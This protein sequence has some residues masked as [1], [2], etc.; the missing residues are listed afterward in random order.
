MNQVNK[1]NNHVKSFRMELL[2]AL[3]LLVCAIFWGS[4]KGT[5]I[6]G[7]GKG[8]YAYLPAAFIYNDFEY[9]F[10][11]SYE[12]DYYEPQS[13]FDF[14][15]EADGEIVNIT[16]IGM[17]VLWLPFFLV[18]HLLSQVFGLPADGYS[19][20]YQYSVGFAA[21]I[22]LLAGLWALRKLLL[23]Y[24]VKALYIAIIQSLIV[25]ATPIYYYTTVEASFT[26]VYSFSLIVLFTYTCKLLFNKGKPRFLYF[27]A[28]ILG[29]II[30]IRPSNIIILAAV[31]FIAGSFEKLKVVVLDS[32]RNYQVLVIGFLITAGIVSLQ[33][34]MWYIQTGLLYVYAYTGLGFNFDDPHMLAVLFSYR[35]GLFIYTPLMF[36]SLLGFAYLI[37]KSTYE[38]F[39]LILFL[40]F[41]TY[42]ISSWCNW[43]YGM[44][45]GHRQYI[46]FYVFFALLLGFAFKLNRLPIRIGLIVFSVLFMIINL[47]QTYQYKNFI[48]YWNMNK[49]MYWRVFL[50]TG[51]EYEG[52][53]WREAE[54]ERHSFTR[55]EASLAIKSSDPIYRFSN[56]YDNDG[57]SNESGTQCYKGNGCFTLNTDQPYSQGFKS[58]ISDL[59]FSNHDAYFESSFYVFIPK[60]EE[61]SFS[62]VFSVEQDSKTY[63]YEKLDGE[64][65]NLP[66][67]QWTKVDLITRLTEYRSE[68]DIIKIYVWYRGTGSIYLDEFEMQVYD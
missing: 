11:D 67:D 44:S 2:I 20:L 7:D 48:L 53:L 50:K 37:R 17:A 32:I 21:I 24:K 8:Y 4:Y 9:N 64:A 26:H 19:I 47:I 23:L 34:L 5:Y 14:R 58:R 25:F 27:T 39:T 66:E 36:L 38:T 54:K 46:D 35:K 28:L 60:G 51:I 63:I 42:I 68:N 40:I 29:L 22:Y 65:L 49:E 62:L 18:A 55:Y 3:L 6:N 43:W 15:R 56:T 59:S 13:Y 12:K 45:F 30:I 31:P 61:P 33:F 1:I 41:L 10:I 16:F 52:L 57:S